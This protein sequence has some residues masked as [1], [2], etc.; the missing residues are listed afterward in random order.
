M[1]IIYAEMVR[2]FWWGM[3]Y[4]GGTNFRMAVIGFSL[5]KQD[6]YARQVIYRLATNYQRYEWGKIWDDVGHKK[7]PV[8]FIDFRQSQSE[9]EELKRRYAFVDWDK[10]VACFDGFDELALE[11]IENK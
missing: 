3:G 5:P 7:A 4:V 1:K 10:A 6:E 11:I 8:V 9:K 2:D